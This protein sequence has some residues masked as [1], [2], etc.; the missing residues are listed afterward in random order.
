MSKTQTP[1]EKQRTT[2]LAPIMVGLLAMMLSN[3]VDASPWH[4][5]LQ[6]AAAI[7]CLFGVYQLSRTMDQ[8]Q[9]R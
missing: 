5:I 7:L 6:I 9:Q 4:V 2:A 3:A 8:R 1:V